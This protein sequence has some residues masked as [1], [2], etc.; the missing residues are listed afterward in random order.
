MGNKGMT[1]YGASHLRAFCTLA[2]RSGNRSICINIKWGILLQIHVFNNLQPA[3]Y[4]NAPI[5]PIH[6]LTL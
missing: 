5:S 6:S 3:T 1:D 2:G 4:N